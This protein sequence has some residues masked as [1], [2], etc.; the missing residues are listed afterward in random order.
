MLR[1]IPNFIS[2]HLAS[3]PRECDRTTCLLFFHPFCNPYFIP[4][5]LPF[6]P[7]LR[8]VPHTQNNAIYSQSTLVP[9]VHRLQAGR[10]FVTS[11]EAVLRGTDLRDSFVSR[12]VVPIIEIV[13]YIIRNQTLEEFFI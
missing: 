8:I 10:F 1:S 6:L 12:H 2:S 13:G 5:A 9:I 3:S 7:L 4:T 11:F